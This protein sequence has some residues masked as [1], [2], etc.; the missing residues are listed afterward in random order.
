[1]WFFCKKSK[2]YEITP[3]NTLHPEL[4]KIMNWQFK[5]YIKRKK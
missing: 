5:Q 2:K 3:P 4:V 1:M